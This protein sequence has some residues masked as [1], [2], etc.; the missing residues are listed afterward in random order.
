[1]S[2]LGG[3]GLIKLPENLLHKSDQNRITGVDLGRVLVVGKYIAYTGRLNC[4]SII[5]GWVEDQQ[6]VIGGR[7]RKEFA[8]V[9]KSSPAAQPFVKEV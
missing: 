9:V 7:S 1:M 4:V 2:I 8:D 3:E 5:A 6:M